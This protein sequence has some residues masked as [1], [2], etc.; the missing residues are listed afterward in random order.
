MDKNAKTLLLVLVI[1]IAMLWLAFASVPLYDL[2]CRV[3]GFGGTTQVSG[4][5]PTQILDRKMTVQFNANTNRNLPWSFKPEKNDMTVNIGAQG[6]I[7]FIAHN[8]SDKP[9]VGTAVYN[10]TP[11]KAGKYFHKTQCFCFDKQLLVPGQKMNM[12][13]VFYV[14]PSIIDDRSM[15]DVSHITLSYSFFETDSK[16]LDEA[17]EAFYNNE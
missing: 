13:V 3:T 8:T 6:M 5:S 16:E 10:V 15:D 14:N 12:P 4:N 2:F 11:A 7:N 1:P 9:T 17:L